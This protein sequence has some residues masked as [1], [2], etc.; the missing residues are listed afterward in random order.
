ME[1]KRF[2]LLLAGCLSFA[3]AHSY[4]YNAGYG[5][6]IALIPPP[7]STLFCTTE[8]FQSDLLYTH[9]EIE[10]VALAPSGST[11]KILPGGPYVRLWPIQSTA[12]HPTHWIRRGPGMPVTQYT[13]TCGWRGL[14]VGSPTS[15]V[16]QGPNS[17]A[18][19]A[20]LG[21]P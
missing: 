10:S 7:Y 15:F 8:I 11:L 9:I 16:Y 1:A 17:D 12:E 3:D 5:T 21:P 4:Y 6:P 20:G 2:S 13:I 18:E 14:Y 19:T